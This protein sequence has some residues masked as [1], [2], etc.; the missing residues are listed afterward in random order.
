MKGDSLSARLEMQAADPG[1]TLDSVR[2]SG[3]NTLERLVARV[4]MG[5]GALSVEAEVRGTLAQ[6]R[7]SVRS[8]L[9]SE[10]ASAIKGVAGEEIERVERRIRAQVDSIIAVRTQ[11]VRDRAAEGR[12][13]IDR[14]V[15]ELS[16]AIETMRA[17]LA[18]ILRSVG[19]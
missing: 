5:I 11:P 9:D 13:D 4:I 16:S 3:L 8:N 17:A 12:V 18:E 10:I 19:G 15:R 6:P 14:R 2:A 7:L 1:W